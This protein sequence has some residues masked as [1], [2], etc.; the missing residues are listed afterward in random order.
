[1]AA[2]LRP[3]EQSVGARSSLAALVRAAR[4]NLLTR[5]INPP[6]SITFLPIELLTFDEERM[7]HTL[8]ATPSDAVPLVHDEAA[9]DVFRYGRD[10]DA[11]LSATG[12]RPGEGHE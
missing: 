4:V 9:E 7:L 5:R 1:M 8:P 10:E 11:G 6:L 2:G 3:I 12:P